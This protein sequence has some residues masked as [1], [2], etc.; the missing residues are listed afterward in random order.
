MSRQLIYRTTRRRSTRES[1]H[2]IQKQLSTMKSYTNRERQQRRRNAMEMP[3]YREARQHPGASEPIRFGLIVPSSNVT[4]ERELP[5]MFARREV[6]EPERIQLPLQPRA[7][8]H[9]HPRRV[10]RDERPGHAGHADAGGCVGGCAGVRL[11][12]CADGR[13]TRRPSPGRAA[14]RR[15]SGGRRPPRSRGDERWGTGGYAPADGRPQDCRGCALP[16][17]ADPA[18]LRLHRGRG[19][20]CRGSPIA[21]GGRQRRGGPARPA[22]PACSCG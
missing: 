21:L 9:R 4:M 19:C 17:S 8:A 1:E 12:G 2:S 6:A 14:T 10:G 16:S 3:K 5:T 15:R 20:G 11:P 18:G 22:E 13:R 7:D